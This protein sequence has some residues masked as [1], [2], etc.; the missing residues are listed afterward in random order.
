MKIANRHKVLIVALVLL[1]CGMNPLSAQRKVVLTPD[2]YKKTGIASFYGSGFEGQLTSTGERFDSRELTAASNTLPLNT[3]VKV[4]NLRNGKWVLVRINDRMAIHN[5]RL[6]D[7]SKG[8]AKK[9]SMIGSGVA[10]VLVQTLPQEFY[11][12]FSVSPDEL[13][14]SSGMAEEGPDV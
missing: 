8:A 3:Y 2:H 7:L 4:T 14:T 9:L 11:I 6:I 13:L 1:I 12:F 5:K 10:R